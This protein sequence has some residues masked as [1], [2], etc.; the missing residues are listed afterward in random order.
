MTTTAAPPAV[1]HPALRAGA[2]DRAGRRA[3]SRLAF[4]LRALAAM[5]AVL[6]VAYL[7]ISYK[8]ADTLSRV[9][10]HALVRTPAYVAPSHEA[11]SFTAADGLTLKGWW[12]AAPSPRERAVVIVH[13]KDQTRI[14]SSFAAGRIARLLL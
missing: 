6:L 4:A 3:P 10:R 7:G 5:V 1:A 13:G 2:R 14:D 11:V 12:F 8:Y 9:E